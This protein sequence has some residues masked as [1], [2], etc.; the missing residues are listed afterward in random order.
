MKKIVYV[1]NINA[2]SFTLL[3]KLSSLNRPMVLIK[4]T[5]TLKNINEEDY[6]YLLELRK[7][8]KKTMNNDI[9]IYE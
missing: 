2:D 3:K 7:D 6:A 4:N 9:I 8:L 5:I 1:K